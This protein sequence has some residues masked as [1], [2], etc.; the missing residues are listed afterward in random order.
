MKEG[1][2][3]RI[4]I[5]VCTRNRP[6]DVRRCVPTI[7]ENRFTD[8]ELVV[9]DQGDTSETSD[10]VAG[11]GDPR[12]KVVPTPTRGLSRAR[13]IALLHSS[14]PVAAFTDDDCICDPDWVG[15]LIGLFDA[16]PR[17]SGVYGRVKPHGDRFGE[18]MFCHCLIDDPD[19]RFVS[20]SVPPH[21][22]LGHGNNM[23][24]RLS[25]FRDVG[26]YNPQMGAGTRLKA[27]EDTDLTYRLLRAGHALMYSPRPLVYHNN[28]NTLAQAGRMDYGY[29]R[30]FVAVFG[31]YALMEDPVAWK[32]LRIRVRELAHDL[33]ESV[34]WSS[35]RRFFQTLYKFWFFAVGACAAVHFR[36]MGDPPWPEEDDRDP[37][38]H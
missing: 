35:W 23:A 7:L 16:N 17:V 20:G 34:K 22:H 9:V 19:E 5:L 26:L 25:V 36:D 14:A 10:Y 13:N 18:G 2:P 1:H 27:G 8:F 11:L 24:F 32:C 29:V 31:K 28:W 21:A 4:S 6:A 3:P 37:A 33:R 12:V 15:S 38:L 30:G